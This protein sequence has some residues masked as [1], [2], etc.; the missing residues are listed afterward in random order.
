MAGGPFCV[1]AMIHA[2]TSTPTHD[3]HLLAFRRLALTAG[4]AFPRVFAVLCWHRRLTL[5]N[6]MRLTPS[7]IAIVLTLF[8]GCTGIRL[9]T[10]EDAL[11]FQPSGPWRGEIHTPALFKQDEFFET[12]DG[13][14]LHAWY[15]PAREPTAVVLF[16]HGNAGALP[17]RIPRLKWMVH[18]L[19]VSVLAFD[20]RGYG[21]SEGCPSEAGLIAD[22]RTARAKLAELADV[23][24]SEIVLYGRSLGGGVLA[25]VA[26]E[27]GAAALV[28]ES[29]FTS[30][31]DVARTKP[32]L[33]PASYMM[34]NQFASID[35]IA[36]YHGPLFMAHGDRDNV[37][38]LR[39]G[40]ELFSAANEPK[41]FITVP[42]AGHDWVPTLDYTVAL[43][44]FLSDSP[45]AQ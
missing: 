35:C 20:Y 34:R 7:A 11:V 2:A 37:V 17:D 43:A 44:R 30:L 9:A 39:L 27:D 18:Q 23:A 3:S 45:S 26:A 14:R 6:S 24:E 8:V 22:A 16:A 36:K 29:T 10:P 4:I 41:K 42:E 32:L 38:P 33:S 12:A 31:P 1:P 15:C 28:L 21:L 13:V 19:G 40:Q 5:T 25:K